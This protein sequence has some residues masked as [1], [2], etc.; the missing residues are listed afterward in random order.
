[1][2]A[3]NNTITTNACLSANDLTRLTSTF[4]PHIQPQPWQAPLLDT[5][6]QVEC[7]HELKQQQ[8]Q[9]NDAETETKA[10]QKAIDG[11]IDKTLA[12][13]KP[14]HE[15]SQKKSNSYYFV[16][17]KFNMSQVKVVT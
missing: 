17:R 11:E 2:A 1:M 7:G 10:E 12:T 4:V 8:Q 16:R 13:N 6:S 5:S 3:V 15:Q 9:Q 14:K